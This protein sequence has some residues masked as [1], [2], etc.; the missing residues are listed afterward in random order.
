[1]RSAGQIAMEKAKARAAARGRSKSP[2]PRMRRASVGEMDFESALA[3]VCRAIDSLEA[4][5]RDA[6]D[7]QALQAVLAELVRDDARGTVRGALDT[8]STA[9]ELDQRSNAPALRRKR[10]ALSARATQLEQKLDEAIA[11]WGSSFSGA[12]A[13]SASPAPMSAKKRASARSK[14]PAPRMRRTAS[15]GEMDFESAL[16]SVCRAI[17]SLEA[18][19]RDADD[20]PTLLAILAELVRDDARGTVRGALDTVST[21]HELGSRSNAAAL[22]ASR[23]A[24][25][26][27]ATW[28]ERELEDAMEYFETEED[29]VPAAAALLPS[30]FAGSSPEQ[31]QHSPGHASSPFGGGAAAAEEPEEARWLQRPWYAYL[32]VALVLL[33]WLLPAQRGLVAK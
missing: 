25:S 3:S 16:A 10:K 14:S 24:L 6:D 32:A 7:A 19:F 28:L 33:S 13:A 9:Y 11:L 17:D 27:R 8:V 1:M 21:A 15:V 5:F 22:R 20:A 26:E 30:R 12:S 23:K 31:Q 18:R 4:R 29:A 2:A